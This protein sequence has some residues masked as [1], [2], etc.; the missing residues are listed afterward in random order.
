M[1]QKLCYQLRMLRKLKGHALFLELLTEILHTTQVSADEHF[2]SD[3]LA[4][5][6]YGFIITI[7]DS[8]GGENVS[9][10]GFKNYTETV[11]TVDRVGD[12]AT[13]YADDVVNLADGGKTIHLY[14]VYAHNKSLASHSRKTAQV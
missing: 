9:L 4:L 11:A 8:G 5:F 14:A 12:G 6:L 13:G 7:C 10:V 3:V 1:G 2:L